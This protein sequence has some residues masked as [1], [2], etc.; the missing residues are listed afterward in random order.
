[1]HLIG[2]KLPAPTKAP[3]PKTAP[4]VRIPRKTEPKKGNQVMKPTTLGD[5]G[6]KVPLCKAEDKGSK[7]PFLYFTTTIS[8]PFST[9]FVQ[10]EVH[11][12]FCQRFKYF[13]YPQ[14]L[15]FPKTSLKLCKIPYF[16]ENP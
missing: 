8:R 10:N 4:K 1:M 6:E 2:G 11:D 16:K 15:Q 13:K 3:R 7:W 12:E 9:A 14:N 5:V